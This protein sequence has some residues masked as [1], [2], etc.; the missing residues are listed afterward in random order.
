MVLVLFGVMR[1]LL[2]AL[3]ASL[4]TVLLT[5]PCFAAHDKELESVYSETLIVP[6]ELRDATKPVADAN[7][8]EAAAQPLQMSQAEVEFLSMFE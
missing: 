3:L 6:P 8:Q 7:L 5:G 1:S 2:T 4:L